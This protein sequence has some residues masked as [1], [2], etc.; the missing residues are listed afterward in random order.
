MKGRFAKKRGVDV[1]KVLG[2][3]LGGPLD[4]DDKGGS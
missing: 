1:D 2:A 4:R 3:Q